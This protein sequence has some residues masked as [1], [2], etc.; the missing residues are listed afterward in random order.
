MTWQ[1]RVLQL[2]LQPTT[3]VGHAPPV[4]WLTAYKAEADTLMHACTLVTSLLPSEL[5]T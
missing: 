3:Q 1:L 4:Q 5:I 2:H